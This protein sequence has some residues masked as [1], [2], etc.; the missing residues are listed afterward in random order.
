MKG[1]LLVGTLALAAGCSLA[2]TD[3][4]I[5]EL[6]KSERSWCVSVTSV[7]GTARLSGSGLL[8]GRVTCTQEGMSI[9]ATPPPQ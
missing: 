5:R 6:V 9:N 2:P 7:Y 1:L 3:D 8:N 4:V